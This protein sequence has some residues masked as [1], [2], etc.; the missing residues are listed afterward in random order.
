VRGAD[1]GT[2]HILVIIK[3]KA[4]LKKTRETTIMNNK[5]RYDVQ[6]L[7][8]H[9]FCKKCAACIDKKIKSLHLGK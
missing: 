9:G 8:Y 6:K 5:G 1:C 3:V 7:V 2:D 4:T